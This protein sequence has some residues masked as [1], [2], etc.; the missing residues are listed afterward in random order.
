MMTNYLIVVPRGNR[1][2]FELLSIAFDGQNGFSVVIDRRGPDAATVADDGAHASA[3]DDD[4]ERRAGR[5]L[6]GPDEIIV[7]ERAERAD[8]Q[9]IAGEP[10]AYRRIPVRRRR[11]G[12]S[13]ARA[14]SASSRPEALAAPAGGGTTAY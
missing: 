5:V 2:L 4:G 13:M 12:R 7:A 6:L 8:R 10:R 3:P 1:E 14:G 11:A 9:V